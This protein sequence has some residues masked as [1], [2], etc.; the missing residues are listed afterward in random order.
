IHALSVHPRR[1]AA[2]A[3]AERERNPT[4]TCLG[5]ATSTPVTSL[6]QTA[7]LERRESADD[8]TSSNRASR[9]AN[10]SHRSPFVTHPPPSRIP[11]PTPPARSAEGL[12]P[13]S[14]LGAF[15]PGP[16]AHSATP[17]ALAR[18]VAPDQCAAEHATQQTST[19][20]PPLRRDLS[21][22]R[23]APLRRPVHRSR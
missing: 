13:R 18:A 12:S 16:P 14:R 11:P 9:S 10:S 7:L 5:R 19:R 15:A 20:V 21:A 6:F 23:P 1:L 22:S 8:A 2:N 17:S 4:P 3:T